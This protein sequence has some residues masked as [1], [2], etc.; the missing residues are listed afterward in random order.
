[1][2]H[3]FNLLKQN[4]LSSFRA[5]LSDKSNANGKRKID[6]NARENGNGNT[7]LMLAVIKKQPAAVKILLDVQTIDVNVQDYESGYTAL[8]KAMYNG[9][10]CIAML[11]WNT[12]RCNILLRDKEGNTC[13]DLLNSTI[14]PPSRYIQNTATHDN[15]EC[16]SITDDASI[17]ETLRSCSTSV[18]TW[19]TNCNYV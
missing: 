18:W 14:A 17:Q 3:L 7:L 2:L 1:M 13:L 19:G 12:G 4:D 16:S 8:H 9:Q 11:I 5:V 15:D 10:L 6:V